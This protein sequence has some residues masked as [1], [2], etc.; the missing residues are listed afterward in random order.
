MAEEKKVVVSAGVVAKQAPEVVA[1]AKEELKEALDK[2]LN[3]N[4]KEEGVQTAQEVIVEVQKKAE[5][6]FTPFERIPSNWII[7]NDDEEEDDFITATCTSRT[8][9]GT[10]AD[11]NKLLRG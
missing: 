10:V 2:S 11:F 6:P 4:G 9:V 8:F 7:V 1:K 5:T 3:D